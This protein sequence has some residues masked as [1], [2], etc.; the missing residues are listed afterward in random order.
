MSDTIVQHTILEAIGLEK[1][2]QVDGTVTHLLKGITLD[3]E[4]NSSYAIMGRSGAGK[5]TLLQTLATLDFLSNGTLL[6]E[7]QSVA[8][9]DQDLLRRE[10]FGFVFQ[11]F[12]L[13]ED[14]TLLDNVLLPAYI[15]QYSTK[16]K[17]S[18]HERALHLLNRCGLL[19]K[20]DLKACHLSGGEKQRTCVARALLLRPQIL[21]LDEPTGSLDKEN[22]VLLMK[23]LFETAKEESSTIVLVT[24]NEE[25]A[26]QAEHRYK[27]EDGLLKKLA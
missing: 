16:E 1:S 10:K 25:L 21:F 9:I 2:Y 7:G 8:R 13:L 18:H 5:T 12:Y 15:A 4:A 14:R 3:I 26:L 19:H 27:L 22:E 24:H 23:L 6:Y 11:F 17:S 20:K